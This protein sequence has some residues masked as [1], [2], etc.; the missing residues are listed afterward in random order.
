VSGRIYSVGYEGMTLGGFVD[1]LVGAR[2]KIVVDVR[3]NPVSRKPSFSRK[4]LE[5]ALNAA[6]IAYVHEKALGNP[7]DNRHSFRTG[8][9]E[10]GRKRM[11]AILADGAGEAL[12]RVV[13]LASNARIAVLCVE[14]DPGRCHRDVITDTAVRRNPSIEVIHIL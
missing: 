3:L 1:R 13:E 14:R 12:D 5:A 8:D 4:R 9:G 10:E 7:A 6:G 2:V 11:R